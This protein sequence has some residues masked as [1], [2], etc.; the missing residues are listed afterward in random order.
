MTVP[1]TLIEMFTTYKVNPVLIISG[2]EFVIL[3]NIKPFI[4]AGVDRNS[5]QLMTDN[6]SKTCKNYDDEAMIC[7]GYVKLNTN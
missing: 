7:D 5:F 6:E 4:L 1:L 2:N 3:T